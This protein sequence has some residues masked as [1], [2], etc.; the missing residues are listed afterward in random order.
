MANCNS[1][2]VRSPK[3]RLNAPLALRATAWAPSRCPPG[4]GFPGHRPYG[5]HRHT[6]MRS[7]HSRSARAG[8]NGWRRC[9]AMKSPQRSHGQTRPAP[10]VEEANEWRR[11]RPAVFIS[12]CSTVAG[13]PLSTAVGRP[14]LCEPGRP[15]SYPRRLSSTAYTGRFLDIDNS[16]RAATLQQIL[17]TQ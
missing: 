17:A 8:A 13:I 11:I 14:V 16:P 5:L 12:P 6:E 3:S 4:N 15:S 9:C 10:A 7:G 1:R 2:V